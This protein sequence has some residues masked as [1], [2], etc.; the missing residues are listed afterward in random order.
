[1]KRVVCFVCVLAAVTHAEVRLNDGAWEL[2][3]AALMVRVNPENAWLSVLEKESGT[4]WQQEDPAR[5]GANRDQV[6]ARRAPGPVAVDGNPAEWRFTPHAEYVWLP[7]K[8]DNGESNCSGGAK[9]MWDERMFYLYVRVRD[10]NVA[11]GGEATTEW[12]ESDSVEF[13]VDAVQVGLHLSPAG[14]EVA[15]NARGEEYA[16]SSV[17]LRLITEDKLPGYELEVAMPLEHFPVLRDPG[18][19]V[20]FSFVIGINDADPEP[21]APVR[22]ARQTYYP[23]SWTHS[24]PATFAVAVLT[25]SDGVA[26]ERTRDNDRSANAA[27]GRVSD[28]ARGPEPNSLEF[29]YTVRR[30]Q[31]VEL[32]L[33][34]TLALVADEPFLDVT[35]ECLAGAESPH[36]AFN[37]P[38]ALYPPEP[39][40]FF[41][42]VANYTNGRY[43]PVGDSFCRNRRFCLGGGDLPFVLVTD[44]TRGLSTILLTPHDAAVQMQTRADD[45]EKLGFPGFHWLPQKGVWGNARRGR[46]AFHAQGGHVAACKTYR[47]LAAAQGLVRTFR[48][49]ARKKPDV[50]K[51]FGAV[52]WWG[53]AGLPFV[54]EAVAAGMRHGLFNGRPGPEDMA[55]IVKLGWLAGEYDNYEDINDSETIARAKAPVKEH[56]VVRADGEFMT[57]WITRDEDMN[58]VHTYM[59]QCTGVMEKCAR[60]IVPKVLATYPYNTRFLDVTTACGLKECYSPLHALTRAQDQRCRE[61]LLAYVGDELGLVAGG[62]HGRYWDVP[63]LDYHEG[64]MGGACYSWPAG[65]LREVKAREELSERYLKYGIDPTNRVPMFELVFHDCVVN[66][67]YWG[68]CSDYLHQVAPELTDRKTAM[69]VLYGTPPMM[70][71]RSRGL[72]WQV[73]EE[74]EK[75]LEIYRNV[76]KLHE[77]IADQE[78]LSHEYVTADRQVQRTVFADGTT[79]TVNFGTVPHSV[80]GP[81]TELV[82]RQNDFAVAGPRIEQWRVSS[83]ATPP[84]VETYIRTD[85]CLFVDQPGRKY[86]VGPASGVGRL[87]ATLMA[88]D[89]LQV[90]LAPGAQSR[91]DLGGWNPAWAD[92][93]VAVFR[94]DTSGELLERLSVP[95]DRVLALQAGAESSARFTVL[96]GAAARQPDVTL[97]DLTITAAGVDVDSDT[98]LAPNA[99]LAVTATVRNTGLAAARDVVVA[100][101]L[102]SAAGPVLARKE[103]G[104]IAPGT[105]ASVSAELA[106]AKADGARR[107]VATAEAAAAIT[108]SG[109]LRLEAG[110][111]GPFVERAF[112]HRW[113][114]RLNVPDGA[115]GGL[116]VEMPFEPGRADPNN[117]RVRFAGGAVV[118]AQFEGGAEGDGTGVLVFVLPDGLPPGVQQASVLGTARG[119]DAVLPYTGRFEVA[120][121]GSRLCFSTYSASIRDGVLSDISIRSADGSEVRVASQ[122]IVSSKETGWSREPGDVTALTLLHSGPVRAVFRCNKRIDA[123]F[124]LTRQWRFY[125]DRFEVLSSCAPAIGCLTRAFYSAD[126]KATNETGNSADMDGQGNGEE[127]GFKGTPQWYAVFSD[128]WRNACIALTP[129]S[130]FT[131]WDSG[132]HRGQIA[133]NTS[134]TG[135]ERRVYIWGGGAETDA[136]AAAA[137]KAY[138]EGV[139]VE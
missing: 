11:F 131:Y 129:S 41:M 135:P 73:P 99:A 97:S 69:N 56:A 128:T 59:K 113:T 133:L 37:F 125:G 115:S 111:T 63:Y 47:K 104:E 43:L 46:L 39:E 121:D 53:A 127:F 90:V 81:G 60:I 42:G 107:V 57:A 93:P 50:R 19:G 95:S 112:P 55:E 33:R 15:V 9:L 123:T 126:A 72:R 120:A 137:A 82:L 3:N 7:W 124:G 100:L 119:S 32:P 88:P 30:G 75:M 86:G 77:V 48:E 64:M 114:V 35:L 106:A 79:C 134:G 65:Y 23:R 71:A 103:F 22:R 29:N 91:L 83:A 61:R 87:W 68:A 85:N 78:M 5:H 101:R 54:K 36:K 122:V 14:R 110:F 62:E 58:P 20:R 74:R 80:T 4:L 92:Q 67:W 66:Y 24:A 25:D 8:G 1:M 52:N 34:V 108:Q 21:D 27:G 132:A 89:R 105:V 31:P 130:S 16:G 40:S 28:M 98:V 38:F 102:D 116:P 109:R 12:W 51:L 118:P 138:R 136:F 45:S 49:K 17:G 44:G 76:C 70:W 18:S 6:R 117:L 84:V 94:A 139:D 26:P 2:E 13:W 10:D 96:L